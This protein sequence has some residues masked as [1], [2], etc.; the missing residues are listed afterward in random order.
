MGEFSTDDIGVCREGAE[1]VGCDLDVV[2]DAWVVV[3]IT[4]RIY[5]W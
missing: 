4:G 2:G 3:A 1:G 5:Q